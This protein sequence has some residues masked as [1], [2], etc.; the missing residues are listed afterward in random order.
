MERLCF[1]FEICEGRE[2]EYLRRHAEMTDDLRQ[3]IQTAGFLNYSLFIRGNQ[4]IGYAECSPNIAEA[5]HQLGESS[6][7]AAW[8][9]RFED[10]VSES[11]TKES[12]PER[13]MEYWHVG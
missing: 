11:G 6:A 9:L 13:A 12:G 5:S 3:E 4:V 7:A 10:I 8:N 2:A 1:T